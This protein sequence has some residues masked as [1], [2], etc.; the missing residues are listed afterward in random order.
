MRFT[1]EDLNC[2][3]PPGTYVARIVDAI[4]KKSRKSNPMVEVQ[5][6]IQHGDCTGEVLKDHFVTGGE[7]RR[8]VQI[9]KRRLVRL[10]RICGVD[11]K[12]GRDANLSDLIGSH[13]AVEVIEDSY[14]NMPVPRVRFYRQIQPGDPDPF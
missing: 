7:S 3:V 14:R 4:E 1:A 10:F 12:P 6:E 9:G 2:Q 11:V 13:L 5:I 8:A